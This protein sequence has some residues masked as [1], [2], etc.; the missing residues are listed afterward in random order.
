MVLEAT[1]AEE[2]I[3]AQVVPKS[4]R[5]RQRAVEVAQLMVP[6]APISKKN[7]LPAAVA[8]Q[9]TALTAPRKR[10]NLHQVAE[11]AKCVRSYDFQ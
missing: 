1:A 10:K 5:K 9:P 8:G 7:P 11:A 2:L 4:K 6:G 3:A